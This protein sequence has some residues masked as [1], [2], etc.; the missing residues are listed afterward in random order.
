MLRD[1]LKMLNFFHS[2]EN[3]LGFYR[4]DNPSGSKSRYYLNI[5]MMMEIKSK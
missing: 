5:K 1:N 3:E 4:I 2:T